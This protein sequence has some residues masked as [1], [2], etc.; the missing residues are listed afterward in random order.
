MPLPTCR[1]WAIL[2][3]ILCLTRQ[4]ISTPICSNMMNSQM[5]MYRAKAPTQNGAPDTSHMHPGEHGRVS[6]WIKN[7]MIALA[8]EKPIY[9]F[10][11]DVIFEDRKPMFLDVDT[12]NTPDGWIPP[13]PGSFYTTGED[14]T[15]MIQRH[16]SFTQA[17]M[18][19]DAQAGSGQDEPAGAAVVRP[20]TIKVPNPEYVPNHKWKQLNCWVHNWFLL[21]IPEQHRHL[22]NDVKRGDVQ[23]LLVKAFGMATREP[24]LYCKVIKTRM[25]NLPLDFRSFDIMGHQWIL[26][27]YEYFDTI[28]DVKCEGTHKMPESSNSSCHCSSAST[29]ITN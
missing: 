15:P 7:S 22:V 13:T 26:D 19:A 24:A 28:Q 23:D 12:V 8:L 21:R 14:G 2:T 10:S 5:S 27:Q 3:L 29:G 1:S 25:Q 20:D 17:S 11:P 9:G 4:R 18:D 16:I 6:S